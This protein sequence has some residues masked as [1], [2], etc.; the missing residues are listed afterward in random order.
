MTVRDLLDLIENYELNYDTSIQ[1]WNVNI[2]GN[3]Q[4]IKIEFDPVHMEF[5]IK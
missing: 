1:D 4:N 3:S 5:V 2:F